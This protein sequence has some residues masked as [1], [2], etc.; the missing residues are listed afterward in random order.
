MEFGFYERQLLVLASFCV[1]LLGI[2]RN[3]A[4]GSIVAKE[5]TENR[6]ENGSRVS[7]RSELTRKYLLVYAIVMGAR[8]IHNL[9]VFAMLIYSFL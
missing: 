3:V 9:N 6:R 8:R 1:V 5:S 7:V 2:E 4:K